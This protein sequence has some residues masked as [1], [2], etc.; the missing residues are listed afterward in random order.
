M[1]MK[2]GHTSAKKQK[3]VQLQKPYIPERYIATHSCDHTIVNNSNQE[4]KM[5]SNKFITQ[6]SSRTNQ[7]VK[8]T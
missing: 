2:T 1:F 6:E 7:F 3:P 4:I 8:I 5:M